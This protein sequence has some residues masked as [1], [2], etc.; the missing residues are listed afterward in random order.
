MQASAAGLSAGAGTSYSHVLSARMCAVSLLDVPLMRRG[1]GG[2]ARG[3]GSAL[4]WNNSSGR[5][6]SAGI[7]AEIRCK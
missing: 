7:S 1:G 5:I 6:D 2:S 4:S 3:C